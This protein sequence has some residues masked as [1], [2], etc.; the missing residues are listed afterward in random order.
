VVCVTC[1]NTNCRHSWDYRGG[2]KVGQLVTCPACGWKVRVRD[3][4][5]A[6]EDAP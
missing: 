1:P 5:P 4:A 3:D 2:K 6:E